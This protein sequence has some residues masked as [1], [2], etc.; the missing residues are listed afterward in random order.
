MFLL[1]WATHAYFYQS[2]Q[3]NEAARFDQIRAIVED[4]TLEINKYW[5]NSADIIH[6]P[7]NS[8]DHIYP[9]KA[10]GMT[11]L[12]VVPFGILSFWLSGFRAFGL[13]EWVYWH[14]LTYPTIVF[15]VS[16][17]SALAAVAIYQV[18][19]RIT[20]DNYFSALVV[21]A[22]WLGTMAFPYSMLFLA[23]NSAAR[24]SQSRFVF[25]SRS[26]GKKSSR[27]GDD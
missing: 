17:L 18:L 27:L 1:L 4:H 14:L 16:L 7:K 2:T 24:C 11:L 20:A 12:S 5:W 25:C 10:P 13:P 21:L 8:S 19:K 23:T 15:T 3:H 9:N 6:Y 22:I 26:A